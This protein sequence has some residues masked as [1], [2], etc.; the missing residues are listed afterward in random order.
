M[1]KKYY[2]LGDDKCDYFLTQEEIKNKGTLYSLH[3]GFNG[4]IN[5]EQ[6]VATLLDDGGDGIKIKFNKEK[7]NLDKMNASQLESLR[8]LLHFHNHN[9]NISTKYTVSVEDEKFNF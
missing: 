2:I 7:L 6:L 5:S 3:Y 4:W 8:I 1:K 9:Y